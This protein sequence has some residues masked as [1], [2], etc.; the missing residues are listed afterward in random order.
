G[1]VRGGAAVAA[2]LPA[3]RGARRPAGRR[4]GPGLGDGRTLG[5]AG[6]GIG[7]LL[8]LPAVTDAP[9]EPA[10][11]GPIGGDMAA[12]VFGLTRR[13]RLAALTARHGSTFVLGLFAF[14]NGLIAIGAMAAV[15]LATGEPFVFPS[16][17]P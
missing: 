4:R 5:A 17:G 14:L 2:D 13:F 15:A 6:R 3:H 9:A 7:R 16:L 1:R 12:I 10:R 11:P 8:P